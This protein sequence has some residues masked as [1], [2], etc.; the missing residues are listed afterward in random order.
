[1]DDIIDISVPLKS[2]MVC[3]PG[4]TGFHLS[5]TMDMSKGDP[6]NNSWIDTDVHIGTHIDAP[7]HSL[8]NGNTVDQ[9]PL[10][11]LIGT[12]FVAYLPDV[13]EITAQTLENHLIPKETKRLL[14]HTRNS[15]IWGK[16]DN[17]FKKDFVAL[18]IDGAEWIVKHGIQ[19]V[20]IDY[21][22]IQQFGESMETHNVMLRK[23]IIIVEGLDLTDVGEGI[24]ELTCLPLR[25]VGSEGSPARAVL[26]RIQR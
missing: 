19:L 7:W 4:S 10:D 18:T 8:P 25:I 17:E 13:T 9:L 6:A 12:A 26:R 11:V 14:F 1:M 23:N 3:W 5:R 20:G 21:L 16:N 2:G 22:S 24:Y 15:K